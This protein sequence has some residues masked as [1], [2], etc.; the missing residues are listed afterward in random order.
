MN[1]LPR[2]VTRRLPAALTV[3]ATAGWLLTVTTPAWAKASAGRFVVSAD[4]KTV[5]DNRTKLTWQ[6]DVP[7][8]GGANSNGTYTWANALTYCSG[9]TAGL[10]GSGWRLPNVRELLSLVDRKQKTAPAI[11]GAV[12][13]DTPNTYFWSATPLQGGSS[14]AWGV[15]FAFGESSGI[16]VTNGIGVRVRCVR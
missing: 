2:W 15:G 8:T 7:A 11:D 10:P 12:F 5:Y 13:P 4:V 3:L 1:D 14:F 16:D 9:N 6:R